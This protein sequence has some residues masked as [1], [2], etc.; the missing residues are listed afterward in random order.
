MLLE[1]AAFMAIN[2]SYFY[3]MCA[4]S[5]P[6]F[7]IISN[8]QWKKFGFDIDFILKLKH[9]ENDCYFSMGDVIQDDL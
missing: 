1:G 3:V 6:L 9:N 5:L 7:M 8:E 2:I 4:S